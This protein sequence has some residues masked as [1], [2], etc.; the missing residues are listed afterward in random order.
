VIAFC[1]EEWSDDDEGDCGPDGQEGPDPS[2][3][4][5]LRCAK[6][7]EEVALLREELMK[8]GGSGI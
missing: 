1:P 4:L 8:V 2:Q 7:E 3:A 5:A 6:L